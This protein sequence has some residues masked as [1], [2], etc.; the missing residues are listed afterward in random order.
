MLVHG[1]CMHVAN[2]AGMWWEHHGI[3]VVAR[4]DTNDPFI[5]YYLVVWVMGFKNMYQLSNGQVS[6]NAATPY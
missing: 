1:V 5:R 4:T 6:G 2:R 3:R